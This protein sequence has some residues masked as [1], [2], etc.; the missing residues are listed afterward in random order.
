MRRIIIALVLL[1]M[2]ANVTYGI[3]IF[4]WQH[5]NRLTVM[6]PVLMQALTSTQ[7]ITRT[8]D[9]LGIGYTISEALP[10]NL[11]EYDVVITSLS[12]YCPG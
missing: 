9:Q 11:V 8:M 12:F 3:N 7:A 4:V 2:L 6:D 5:D 10:D 1:A